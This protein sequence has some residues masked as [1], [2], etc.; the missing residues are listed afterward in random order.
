[1]H[2]P[3]IK[4]RFWLLAGLGMILAGAGPAARGGEK[5][6]ITDSEQPPSK[7]EQSKKPRP[8]RSWRFENPLDRIGRPGG[9]SLEGVTAPP[10]APNTPGLE[11]TPP[12]TEKELRE[13]KQRQNWI[14]R[15]TRDFSGSEAD[16]H[17]ILGVRDPEQPGAAEDPKANKGWLT[18]YYDELGKSQT[19]AGRGAPDSLRD[20]DRQKRDR[21]NP[22][23]FPELSNRMRPDA[24][25]SL[26]PIEAGG[27][28]GSEGAPWR[29]SNTATADPYEIQPDLE[30]GPNRQ[31]DWLRRSPGTGRDRSSVSPVFAPQSL[32]DESPSGSPLQGVARILGNNPIGNPLATA[33]ISSLDPVTV[34]PDPT[35]E[36]LNPVKPVEGR[37]Q[38]LQPSGLAGMENPG[39]GRLLTT[40]PGVLGNEPSAAQRM[41]ISQPVGGTTEERRP[42][43]SIKVNLDM[44]RRS[45]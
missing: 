43:H 40:S 44:P 37:V 17:R 31:P 4:T 45:F 3:G 32:P 7:L 29:D 38:P 20:R 42:L 30:R 8:Q 5:V 15:T 34:Y 35:R 39:R 11:L 33:P 24:S 9:S 27:F 19:E 12:L 22:P 25:T 36:A 1:M 10:F 13:W 21:T 28:A 2:A 6:T 14:Q 18:E 41:G 26:Q 16:P 23:G